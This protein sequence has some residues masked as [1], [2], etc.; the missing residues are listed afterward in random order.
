MSALALT[1]SPIG[2]LAWLAHLYDQW[3]E[4]EIGAD[5]VLTATSLMW[6]T[7]T[8]RSSMRLYSEPAGAW[9]ASSW[10]DGDA[11]AGE[12]PNAQSWGEANGY[13]PDPASAGG[14]SDGSW[15]PARIETP[16]AFALFPHDLAM[17][18]RALA[19]R[20][21]AVERFTVMPRGGHFAALEQPS[22][23]AEDMIAFLNGH[24]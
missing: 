1:D 3:S 7:G 8:V 19:D 9:D 22:L 10:D 6:L 11:P 24:T 15:T 17:A 13:T 23:L 4:D 18:P 14:E 16:T 12:D 20:H 5:D 21:F 2:L